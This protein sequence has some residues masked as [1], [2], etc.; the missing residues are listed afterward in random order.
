MNLLTSPVEGPVHELTCGDQNQMPHRSEILQGGCDLRP[1]GQA[2]DENANGGGGCDFA[3]ENRHGLLLFS[4]AMFVPY[5]FSLSKNKIRTYSKGIIFPSLSVTTRS[6]LAASS[7]LWVAINAAT[8][9]VRTR[10]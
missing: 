7:W 9:L 2:N 5:M 6:I 4:V 3:E 1:T 8:P 10:P